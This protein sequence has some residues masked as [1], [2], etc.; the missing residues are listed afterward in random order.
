VR[1][2]RLTGTLWWAQA[3]ALTAEGQLWAD[4]DVIATGV[5]S[6]AVHAAAC[7]WT[8]RDHVARLAPW[9]AHA[10]GTVGARRQSVR[11]GGGGSRGVA[12]RVCVSLDVRVCVLESVC[13]CAFMCA[14]SLCVYARAVLIDGCLALQI[15]VWRT[16]TLHLHPTTSG[17]A[18]SS[19]AQSSSLSHHTACPSP[20]RQASER[21]RER[22]RA[23]VCVCMYAWLPVYVCVCACGCTGVCRPHGL[24]VCVYGGLTIVYCAFATALPTMADATWQ[25]GDYLS[26]CARAG[27]RASRTQRVRVTYRHKHGGP[28]TPLSL[29]H[30]HTCSCIPTCPPVHSFSFSLSLC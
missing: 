15:C 23:C 18:C 21:A 6:A 14:F 5:T 17:R 29:T 10:A 27:R 8:G 1:A 25:F 19:A 16:G 20:C 24:C 28:P 2:H 12:C 3:L 7:V 22:E 30:I 26:A 13:V 9:S 11:G 4:D